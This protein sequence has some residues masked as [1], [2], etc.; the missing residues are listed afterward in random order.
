MTVQ[1][2]IDNVI[3]KIFLWFIPYSVKPNHVTYLRFILIPIMAWL[4]AI[5]RYDFGLIVFII[6][7]S[8]DFLD[9]AMARTRNQIT[10]LGKVIDPIADKLLILVALFYLGF[11]YLIIQIIAVF[12]VIEILA[13]IASGTL[14]IK[15]HKPVGANVYGKIKMIFQSVGAGLFMLGLIIDNQ[16]VIDWSLGIMVAAFIFAILSGIDQVR[17]NIRNKRANQ[18]TS[19]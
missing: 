14:D 8:T 19:K 12:I 11:E 6:A 15:I 17:L 3:D 16:P 18:V 1:Q 5:K 9:G 10:D 13:M 2:R 4:F 7:A